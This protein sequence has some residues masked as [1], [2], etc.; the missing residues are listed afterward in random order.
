MKE[1]VFSEGQLPLKNIKIVDLTQ[2]LAG[3]FASMMLG[4]MGAEI[5]KIEAA[6]RG[7]VSRNMDPSP[8]YFNSFNRN[9][10]SVGINLKSDR[11]QQIAHDLL[12]DADVFIENTK[13]GRAATFNLSYEDVGKINENIVYCSISGFGQDSPYEDM[14]ALDLLIQAMSGVMS[15]TGPEDGPPMWSGLPSGDLAAT[16][17]AVQS[18][19]AALYARERGEIDSEYIEVPMFDTT[20]SWLTNRIAYTFENGEPFPR[21]GSK[22]PTVAPFGVFSCADGLVAVVVSGKQM[23]EDFCDVIGRPDLVD[24]TRFKTNDHRLENREQLRNIIEDEFA[25]NTVNEWFQRL[26]KQEIPAGPIND[27]KTVWDDKHVE[28]RGLRQSMTSDDRG[29]IDVVDHPVRFAN[30]DTELETPP[31]KL[32]MHTDETLEDLGYSENEIESLRSDGV[33]Q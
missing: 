25:T 23:W 27:T 9:K 21:S 5:I 2:V 10:Q 17:Y 22:H 14:P 15:V 13:P 20:L 16:M 33:V 7:D 19:V 4:D 30:L 29:E 32:G 12:E 1:E 24:D 6:G 26:R 8:G 31:P 28:Q 3:P 18:I 11:G